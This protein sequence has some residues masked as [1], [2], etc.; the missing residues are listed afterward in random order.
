MLREIRVLYGRSLNARKNRS[1][2]SSHDVTVL[3]ATF[4][5]RARAETEIGL[6][7][8]SASMMYSV[9]ILSIRRTANSSR[10]SSRMTWL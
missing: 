2:T 1:S 3:C 4:S 8:R 10:M 6:A 9:S 5:V 7:T